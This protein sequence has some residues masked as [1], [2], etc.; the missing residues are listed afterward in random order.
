MIRWPLFPLS[1]VYGIVVRLRNWFYTIG[2]L[3]S[4]KFPIPVIA[5]GNLSVGGTGKSPHSIYIV[6]LLKDKYKIAV[7]SRGYGRKTSGYKVANYNTNYREIGDEPMQMF[8]R[9]R[10]R[11]VVGVCEDRVLGVKKLIKEFKPEVIVLDDAFQHRRINAGLN[12]L[13]TDVNFPYYEDYLLPAGNLREPRKSAQRADIVVV[14]KCNLD[15]INK[16]EIKQK[17]KLKETQPVFFSRV[18]YSDEII[19][20]NFPMKLTELKEYQVILITGIA[21]E[22]EFVDFVK[23]KVENVHH[24]SFKDHHHFTQKDVDSFINKYNTL[25]GNKIYLTTEK[26]YMRLIPYK[27][28][29]DELFYLP[30]NIEIDNNEQFNTLIQK[31][32]TTN[33]TNR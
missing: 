9:F 32:V 15:T 23:T 30:I 10:N 7:L 14:T 1:I 5:L 24:F 20:R 13:L 26:D 17:L 3:K 19:G 2:L 28:I 31:Y 12:I 21:K 22:K 8:L 29:L 4:T 25:Q 27:S 11:I 18:I 6:N 33:T 16:S